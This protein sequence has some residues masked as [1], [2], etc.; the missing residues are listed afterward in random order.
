[1]ALAVHSFANRMVTLADVQAARDRIRGSIYLSPCAKSE[2]FS[3]L[4][5]NA[6]YL[7]LDNLQRTGAY[8]ERGAL[9]K[10]LTL[11]A[12]E[13]PAVSSRHRQGTMPR[14]SRIT[15]GASASA[16]RSSCRASRRT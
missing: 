2:T 4:T 6:V 1:M 14:A 8:K 9:N 13:K 3:Q 10:L 12:E 7:K 11:S 15:P 5:G 16:R